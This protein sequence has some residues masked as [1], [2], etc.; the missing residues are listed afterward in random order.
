MVSN[1]GR[2]EHLPRAFKTAKLWAGLL[3]LRR[4]AC[5]TQR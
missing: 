3:T 2:P 5:T 4:S 1:S